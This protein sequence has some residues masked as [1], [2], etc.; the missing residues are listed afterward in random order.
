MSFDLC[1]GACQPNCVK[2]TEN[3]QSS[4][5]C[6][7]SII[8]PP[9]VKPFQLTHPAKGGGGDGNHSPLEIVIIACLIFCLLLTDR[10]TLGLPEYKIKVV[11]IC[12][13]HRTGC[14][15]SMVLCAF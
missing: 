7:I 13:M 1:K 3:N 15:E 10:L 9:M 5:I 14:L 2:M 8:N 11:N 4:N 6:Q 12:K